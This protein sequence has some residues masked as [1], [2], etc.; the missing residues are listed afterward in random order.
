MIKPN[1][2]FLKVEDHKLVSYTNKFPYSRG[3]SLEIR[4]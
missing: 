2:F 1:N 4:L 3:V